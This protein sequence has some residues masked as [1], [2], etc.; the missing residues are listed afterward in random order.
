MYQ[1][2][3]IQ[4]Y[5]SGEEHAFNDINYSAAGLDLITS[6][7]TE[8]Q[9]AAYIYYG[10]IARIP[11]E[12]DFEELIENSEFSMDGKVIS[13]RS[14]ING[15]LI[16]IYARGEISDTTNLYEGALYAW[17]RGYTSDEQA[18]FFYISQGLHVEI[19]NARRIRGM[20]IWP[21]KSS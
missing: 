6:D 11:S 17:S 2:G 8:Q 12:Q 3:A 7:L 1:W 19:T 21:I 20:L 13:I 18:K 15:N 14:K 9:D 10:G 5:S 16:R 4:G